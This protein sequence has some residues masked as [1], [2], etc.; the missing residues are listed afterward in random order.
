MLN[1]GC[2]TVGKQEVSVTKAPED[3][4]AWQA[5]IAG[6]SKVDI[7]VANVDGKAPAR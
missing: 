6:C 7:A 3:A 1:K 2:G 5:S 4:D